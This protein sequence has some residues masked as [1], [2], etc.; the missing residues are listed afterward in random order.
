MR[1]QILGTAAAE[2]VPARFCECPVC[3]KARELKGKE[4]RRRASYLIDDDILV[5]FGQDSFFQ[6]IEYNIDY[7]KL[8]RLIITHP[9]PDHLMTSELH[10][11]FS[12]S[13][14]KVS[15]FI[16]VY[17]GH[18]VFATIM[19]DI[20][21]GCGAVTMEDLCMKKVLML[22]GKEVVE[23]NF[24]ILPMA[25]NHMPGGTP[26]IYVITRDNK[27][28]LIC[29]DTGWMCD[30][31]WATLAGQEVDLALIDSTC[32]IA[33]PD[34]RNGHMGVNTVKAVAAKLKEIK[35]VKDSARI[36]ATHF[37]HNG[38]GNHGD[39]EAVYNP[40]GIEVAYDGMVIEL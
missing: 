28:V 3:C 15:Q 35:A 4:I 32:G 7:L 18:R 1:F 14:S 29:N 30:E 26:M 27:K 12:E 39:Y 33:Y 13:Y 38:G 10:W 9:H 23:E 2:A 21:R 36:I 25:A 37:S 16:T 11:R 17:G 8:K 20:C 31:T 40:L 34:I 6:E 24:A 22:P 5:D 19:G